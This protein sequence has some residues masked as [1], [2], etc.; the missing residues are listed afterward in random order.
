[1]EHTMGWKNIMNMY[2][3][4]QDRIDQI[5]KRNLENTAET[6]PALIN[7]EVYPIGDHGHAV[8]FNYGTLNEDGRVK[9]LHSVKTFDGRKWS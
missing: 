5:I 2:T 6:T 7:H 4:T 9:Q 1:M 8:Q 3:H